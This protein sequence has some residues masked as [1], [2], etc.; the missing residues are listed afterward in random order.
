MGFTLIMGFVIGEQ[1]SRALV[2]MKLTILGI[3]IT[4]VLP[5]DKV[6]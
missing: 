4:R 6:K 1:E 3:K 2:D 5:G